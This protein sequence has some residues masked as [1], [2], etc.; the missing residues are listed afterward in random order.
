MNAPEQNPEDELLRPH[1]YDGIQEYDKRL[2]N[3]WLFTLYGAIVFAAGYWAYYHW[4]DHMQPGWVR[5]KSEL[6]ALSLAAL[7]EGGAPTGEQIYNFSKD[8]AIVAAGQKTYTSTCVACHGADLKG[9]IG[10]DLTD[11]TWIHG[12]T[13]MDIFNTIRNGV[14]EKGM[15]SWGP[16]LGQKRIAEVAAFVISKNPT[17]NQDRKAESGDRKEETAA[18][19]PSQ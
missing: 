9:G 7:K 10:Q 13:P 14:V 8:P 11:A 6:E 12:G 19:P 5:V 4:T 17:V 1:T 15:P 16:L 3:W 2:P 18:S